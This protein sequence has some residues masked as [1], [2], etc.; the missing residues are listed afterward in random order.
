MEKPNTY[1]KEIPVFF[2][3]IIEDL[4]ELKKAKRRA[5]KRDWSLCAQAIT[6]LRNI[7]VERCIGMIKRGLSEKEC[8]Q[9]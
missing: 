4:E 5:P 3:E 7:S 9:S 1:Q 6:R 2:L 8:K